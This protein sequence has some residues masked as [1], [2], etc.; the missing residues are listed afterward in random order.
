MAV[1]IKNSGCT[2]A[3]ELTWRA[4]FEVRPIGDADKIVLDSSA[5]GVKQVLPPG[6]SL[7]YKYTFP[8][9]DSR[10]DEML[11]AETVA[12]FAV[13]RNSVQR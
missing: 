4:K 5:A 9:W 6:E 7:S 10:I 2:P 3:I 1:N 12:I 8:T 11:A 13:R